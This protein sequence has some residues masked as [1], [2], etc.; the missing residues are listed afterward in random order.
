MN[1]IRTDLWRNPLPSFVR[2]RDS[3]MGQ[4]TPR[5]SQV[6]ISAA[7]ADLDNYH[8]DENYGEENNQL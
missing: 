4:P 8:R 7:T 2:K 1:Y 3:I 6:A 5:Q